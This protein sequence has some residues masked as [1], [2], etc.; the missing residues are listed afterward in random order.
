MADRA[1]VFVGPSLPDP[2]ASEGIVYRPPARRGDVLRAAEQGTSL[3]GLVD[4]LLVNELAVTPSEVRE[5]ARRG[6]I[7]LGAASLGALRAVECPSAMV[8]IG[9][10]F[11]AYRDGRLTD[12]DEVVGTFSDGFAPVARPLIVLR[13]RLAAGLRDELLTRTEHDLI[14]DGI[15]RLPFDERTDAAV[16]GVAQSLGGVPLRSRLAAAFRA[17][18]LDIKARDTLALIARVRALLNAQRG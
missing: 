3:I 17:P 14:L 5:A 12:D 4:G 1:I 9:S 15:R 11:E 2:P 18:D 10:V 6:A 7:L 16:L 13:E 8:G